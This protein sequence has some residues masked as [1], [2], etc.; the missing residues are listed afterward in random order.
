MTSFYP[1]QCQLCEHFRPEELDT[2][3]DKPPVWTCAA[4]PEGIPDAI[5]E[6]R[7]DHREPYMGDGGIRWA[8]YRKDGLGT[9]RGHLEASWAAWAAEDEPDG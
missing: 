9:S 5:R 1:T 3:G 6:M 8:P 7:V 2:T 4:F